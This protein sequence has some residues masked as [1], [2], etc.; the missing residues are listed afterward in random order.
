[1][2][3]RERITVFNNSIDTKQLQKERASITDQDIIDLQD[4]EFG[5]SRHIAI[6]VGG[7]YAEKRIDFLLDASELVRRQVPDFHLIVIG[8]GPEKHKIDEAAGVFPWIHPFGSMFGPRKTL[9]VAASRAMLMPG[10]VGLGVLDSFAYGCPLLTTTYPYHSPEIDYL[11]HCVNGMMIHPHDDIQNYANGVVE[12]LTDDKLNR[13]LVRGAK[14]SAKFYTIE[15]MVSRFKAGIIAA[16][17]AD[18]R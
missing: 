13:W 8:N 12:L 15:N 7:L 3:P 6:Y 11:K 4:R 10:L 1:M 2:F 9:Y 16:L 5:G 17:K 14:Q 18:P